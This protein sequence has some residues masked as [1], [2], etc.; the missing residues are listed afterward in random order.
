MADGKWSVAQG[1]VAR[2][3]VALEFLRFPI[4]DSR[5]SSFRLLFDLLDFEEAV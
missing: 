3:T 2:E 4:R 5:S 1:R